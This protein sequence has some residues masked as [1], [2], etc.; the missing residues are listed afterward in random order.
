MSLN[1]FK[2][3]LVLALVTA[4]NTVFALATVGAA[5]KGDARAVASRIIKYNFPTC[6]NVSNANR[7]QDG[8]IRARCDSTDYM[9][10]TIFNAKEGRAV[11]VAMNCT[12]AKSLLNVSC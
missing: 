11:E 6:K 12:A 7:M 4:V 1:V 2:S 9:V 8:S 5:P 3:L 10:F